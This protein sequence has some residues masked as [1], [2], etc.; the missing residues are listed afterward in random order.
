MKN[1]F[2]LLILFATFNLITSC[3]TIVGGSKYYAHVKVKDHPNA[4]I[5]FQGVSQ[6]TGDAVFKVK[7]AKANKL[8]I[9]IKEDGCES[10][11]VNYTERTFRGWAFAGTVIGWTGIIGNVPLP[12][13][14]AVDLAT[15]ALWKPNITERGIKKIDYKHYNYLIDY[16][17]CNIAAT[18]N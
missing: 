8:S 2:Y 15:G 4:T 18:K 10:Q 9:T 14:V 3:A 6:G 1:L 13:G 12:W 11:T 5:E 17:G 7:R 16:D